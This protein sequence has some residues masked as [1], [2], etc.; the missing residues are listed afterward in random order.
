MTGKMKNNLPHKP[1]NLNYIPR[2][3]EK[4]EE[5]C[6]KSYSLNPAYMPPQSVHAH[7]HTNITYT[8]TYKHTK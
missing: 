5:N 8:E 1:E 4:A 6:L 7:I 3:H 2:T